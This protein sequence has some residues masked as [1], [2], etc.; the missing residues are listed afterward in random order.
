MRPRDQF[1]AMVAVEV[2]RGDGADPSRGINDG[3]RLRRGKPDADFG[4]VA[5]AIEGRAIVLAV[6][7][8]V[9]DDRAG[10]RDGAAGRRHETGTRDCE[11]SAA[12]SPAAHRPD[13][14]ASAARS[15][16][17]AVCPE[18]S[19]PEAWPETFER[20]ASR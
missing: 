7:V 14:R 2:A 12:R 19:S 10:R 8:E 20:T 18:G 15:I 16:A 3:G 17:T 11:Y 9:T 6:S 13:Y 1:V 4:R 5:S